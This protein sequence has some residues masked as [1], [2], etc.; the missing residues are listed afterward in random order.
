MHIYTCIY[1]SQMYYPFSHGSTKLTSHALPLGRFPKANPG[2]KPYD[3]LMKSAKAKEI[4]EKNPA[5]AKTIMEDKK[6]KLDISALCL[7]LRYCC[8]LRKNA[9]AWSSLS[10]LEGAFWRPRECAP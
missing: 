9:S 3:V 7:L 8:G 5:M 10:H 1:V 6:E 4:L 2:K